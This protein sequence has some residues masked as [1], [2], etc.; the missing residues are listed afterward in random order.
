MQFIYD[1]IILGL[2]A[3]LGWVFILVAI[4]GVCSIV[5]FGHMLLDKWWKEP[6]R[7]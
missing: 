2:Q 4:I 5:Y 3:T 1:C 7:I 6:R